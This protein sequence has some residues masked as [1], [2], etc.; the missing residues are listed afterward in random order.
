MSPLLI[1]LIALSL[2]FLALV[3]FLIA[4]ARSAG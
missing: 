3:A 2:Y 1:A 4:I